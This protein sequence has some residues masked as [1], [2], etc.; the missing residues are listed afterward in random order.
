MYLGMILLE[1][2]EIRNKLRL[3]FKKMLWTN[4]LPGGGLFGTHV[5][6]ISKFDFILK[7]V[8]KFYLNAILV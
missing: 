6:H 4:W 7:A 3:D 5:C 2:S 1:L 8:C